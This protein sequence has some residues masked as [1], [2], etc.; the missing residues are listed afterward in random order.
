MVDIERIEDNGEL[1]AILIKG[2]NYDE[3][4]N[5]PTENDLP[6]QLGLHNQ[7]KGT[8]LK[9]HIHFPIENIESVPN[10][11]VFYI[12]KGKIKISLY[13]KNKEKIK[14]IIA[15]E[16]NIVYLTSGHGFEF[17]EDTSMFEIKQGPYRDKEHDKEMIE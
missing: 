17:L 11:E 14:D 7:K 6:I 15:T 10:T 12:K 2:E 8:I 16:G 9:S 3:G 13:N 4:V 1:L 5:F